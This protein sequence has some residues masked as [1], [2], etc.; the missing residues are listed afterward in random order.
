MYIFC[1]RPG[2]LPDEYKIFSVINGF[3][4]FHHGTDEASD[5]NKEEDE[6]NPLLQTRKG[7][8]RCSVVI[9]FSPK[10]TTEAWK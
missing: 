1:K 6:E 4:M 9:I 10:A 7:H 8:T 2:Y 5:S 3:Y